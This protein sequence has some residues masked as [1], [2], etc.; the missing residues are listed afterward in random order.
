MEK[1]RNECW[2]HGRGWIKRRYQGST[3]VTRAP[4]ATPPRKTAFPEESVVLA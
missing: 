4:T 1:P 2:S 3:E